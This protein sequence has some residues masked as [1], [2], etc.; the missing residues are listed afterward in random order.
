MFF[1]CGGRRLTTARTD[2]AFGECRRST[3]LPRVLPA[4]RLIYSKL[5]ANGIF[6]ILLPTVIL[7]LQ[8]NCS[9]FGVI[10]IGKQ[11]INAVGGYGVI[12][13]KKAIEE[14]LVRHETEDFSRSFIYVLTPFFGLLPTG[15]AGVVPSE[16]AAYSACP[17]VFV[18]SV[19]DML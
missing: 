7:I 19:L 3:I 1:L 16:E 15:L 4:Y 17:Y 18:F 10:G 2:F 12:F 5:I 6:G 14:R 13:G 11:L 9:A 8:E